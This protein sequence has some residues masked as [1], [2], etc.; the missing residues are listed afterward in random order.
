ML[1]ND[2]RVRLLIVSLIIV[3]ALSC[4]AALHLAWRR[5][6]SLPAW[7]VGRREGEDLSHEVQAEADKS[8]PASIVKNESLHDV[9]IRRLREYPDERFFVVMNV[10]EGISGWYH[11]LLEMMVLAGKL[12]RT[13]VEP[14]VRDGRIVTCVPGKVVAVPYG[15][16]ELDATTLQATRPFADA[17]MLPTL[18][19]SCDRISAA[20]PTL[21]SETDGSEPGYR[22]VAAAVDDSL[23]DG[24]S[25]PL[26]AYLNMSA[27]TQLYPRW[28]TFDLWWELENARADPEVVRRG[29]TR[30][31]APVAYCAGKTGGR[32]IDPVCAHPVGPFRVAPFT[33]DRIITRWDNPHRN[34]GGGARRAGRG[35]GSSPRS[36]PET[37]HLLASLRMLRS[38]DHITMFLFNVWRG[39]VAPIDTFPLLPSFNPIHYEAVRMWVDRT[40]PVDERTGRSRYAAFQ[41]RSES[42]PDHKL[43]ACAASLAGIARSVMAG[44][45]ASGELK[46]TVQPLAS[47]ASTRGGNTTAAAIP[48]P[49]GVLLADMPAPN[50]RCKLWPVYEGS[51]RRENRAAMRDMLRL[52]G[53]AKYDAS[54]MRVDAGV[55]SIRDFIL[56]SEADWFVTCR[57]SRGRDCRDCFRANSFFTKKLLDTRRAAGRPSFT[58]WLSMSGRD[59]VYTGVEVG[60]ST[61]VL[62]TQVTSGGKRDASRGDVAEW[63]RDVEGYR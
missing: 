42:V 54:H 20:F 45:V 12:R 60:S 26:H 13:L 53:L 3:A 7:A 43:R 37:Q 40:V 11:A 29:A 58:Q 52:S 33:F 28:I 32:D 41:W 38:D 5:R 50:H 9:A 18:G 39:G 44:V 10:A 24:S 51:M 19:D 31:T 21:G 17:L 62:A 59:L 22:P 23:D 25:Y 35:G 2:G 57:G 6:S 55:L 36:R 63:P 1:A 47:P 30:L 16:A 49:L 8:A 34:S 15:V 4:S 56:G 61:T 46:L 27:L 14:C 48:A